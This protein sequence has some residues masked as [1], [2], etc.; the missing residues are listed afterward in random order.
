MTDDHHHAHDA[1]AVSFGVLTISSSR[2]VETDASG[3]ALV[4]AI[5]D[6]DHAVAV[7]DLVG[8]D[9]RAIRRRVEGVVD[10]DDVDAVVTTGGTGLTP[11]DVTPEAVDPLFDREIPGFG[12][13]F[14]AQSVDEVGP[15]GMLT[16]ATAGIADGTPVFCLPGSEQAAAFGATELVVPVVGHVVGLTGGGH[17]HSHDHHDEDH[18]GPEGEDH[19]DHHDG[20]HQ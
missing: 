9:E 6:A 18:H 11:E 10:R 13:Q 16:R 14:R 17:E 20:D 5:E 4:A 1:E 19:Y 2:T 15:H 8:D 12:E 7:R 3:D